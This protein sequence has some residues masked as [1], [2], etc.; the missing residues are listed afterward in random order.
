M[1]RRASRL[2]AA[3]DTLQPVP[4]LDGDGCFRQDFQ[5][6]GG[7]GW[8]AGHPNDRRHPSQSA[9]DGLQPAKGGGLPRH[10]GRT[11]AEDAGRDRTL[12][13]KMTRTIW[14]ILTNEEDYRDLAKAVTV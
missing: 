8:P 7:R 6:F 12:V 2:R 4:A 11:K 3:Q 14:A 5:Q 13:N 9:S 10:I 1:E